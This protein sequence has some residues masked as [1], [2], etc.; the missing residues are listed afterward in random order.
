M[1]WFRIFD[2]SFTFHVTLDKH[3]VNDDLLQKLIHNSSIIS[4]DCV[5]LL[6][7]KFDFSPLLGFYS[8]L[9]KSSGFVEPK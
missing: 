1:E 7:V 8:L 5:Y 3:S 4:N 6:E 2:V 9:F